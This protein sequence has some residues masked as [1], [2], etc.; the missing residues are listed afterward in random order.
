MDD[1]AFREAEAALVVMASS[2]LPMDGLIEEISKINRTG[3]HT[4]QAFDPL[5][6]TGRAHLVWAYINALSSFRSGSNISGSVAL[7]MLLFAALTSQIEEAIKRVGAKSS[8]AFVLFAGSKPALA[9]A[10]RFATVAGNF[11]PGRDE[12]LKAARRLGIAGTR[13]IDGQLI[14][15][16]AVS[17]LER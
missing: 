14:Q 6:V 10:R 16:M 8:R 13:D 15:K 7:E 3:K 12:S 1:A 9:M 2:G 5:S 17:R 4:L 11:N